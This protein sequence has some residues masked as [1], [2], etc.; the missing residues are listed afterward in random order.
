[1]AGALFSEDSPLMTAILVSVST[2]SC[3]LIAGYEDLVP[4]LDF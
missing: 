2:V 1:V 3:F 4:D